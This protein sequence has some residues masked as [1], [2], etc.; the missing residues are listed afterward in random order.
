[1]TDGERT[2]SRGTFLKGAGAIAALAL[3]PLG[4]TALAA[5]APKRGGQ[6][7]VGYVGVGPQRRSTQCSA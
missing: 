1:M 4:G 3:T 5:T 7:R 2:L 6:L